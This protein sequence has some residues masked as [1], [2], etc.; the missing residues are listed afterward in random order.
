M[1][2]DG[3]RCDQTSPLTAQ[4]P[5]SNPRNFNGISPD[6]E[7]VESTVM[8]ELKQQQLGLGSPS[9]VVSCLRLTW[10]A[11]APLTVVTGDSDCPAV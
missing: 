8:D 4:C 3:K 1:D 5:E 11:T 2:I 7:A 6:R 10:Q 9:L